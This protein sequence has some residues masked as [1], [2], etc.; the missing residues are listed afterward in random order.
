MLFC[1]LDYTTSIEVLIW[2][3]ILVTHKNLQITHRIIHSVDQNIC[4]L[5]VVTVPVE[6]IMGSIG[7]VHVLICLTLLKYLYIFICIAVRVAK[8]FSSVLWGRI[9]LMLV[10][11]KINVLST[12]DKEIV[13]SIA[14]IRNVSLWVWK[15]KLSRY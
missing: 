15:E 2:W 10:V 1:F 9:Y 7:I 13:V 11:K 5:F 12:N 3:I 14:D 4:V 6:S 8:D